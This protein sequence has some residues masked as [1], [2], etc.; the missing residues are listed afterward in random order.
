MP[1]KR[2]SALGIH[3]RGIVQ[4][5]GFRPFVYQ[6]AVKNNLTGW[7]CN[8]SD[9]VD[10][11]INGDSTSLELFLN[12]LTSSP[13]PLARIDEIKSHS[14]HPNAYTQFTILESRSDP[15]NFIPISPDISICPDCLRELFDPA[16]HRYRYPFINCTNCGPRFTI[17]KNIP[18][19]RPFTTMAEFPMC[20]DCRA[21]YDNPLDRRFHAQPVACKTCGPSLSFLEN[22][23]IT[24]SHEEALAAARSTLRVGKVLAVKGL[25]GYHLACDASNTDAVRELRRRK[26]RVEKPFALMAFDLDVIRRYCHISDQEQELLKSRQRPIVLLQRLPDCPLPEDLAPGQKTL[27]FMLPYTPLHYLLLEPE[28]GFPD[29][30]VMTS[31]NLS[32]EPIAYQDTDAMERLSPLADAFLTHNRDIHIRVDDSVARVVHKSPV[33]IRRSR[34]YAPDPLPL[35]FSFPQIFAAGAE[36]KNH[37]TLTRDSYAFH[38]H[39]I[40]DLEN[41]ETLKSYEQAVDHFENLFR[42]QP[43]MLACDLHPDY[44]STRYT[45]SRSREQNIPVVQV[46]HH[47]AH[48]AACLLDNSRAT[49]EPVIGLIFDGTGYGTDGTIWGGEVLAGG[50]TGYQRRFHLAEFRL[51][52]GD[53]AVRT[54]ARIAL[55]ILQS[56]GFDWQKDLSP[57]RYFSENE[58]EVIR[59]QILSRINTPLTTSM[60]R[61]FD[62]VSSLIGIRQQITY[63]GQAA[64]E[65]EALVDPSEKESYTFDL[66]GTIINHQKVFAQILS[67]LE[68]NL[69]TSR[70][71]AR[72][73]NAV[74]HLCLDV[75]LS[76]KEETGIKTAALSGGV[77]QNTCLY[78]KTAELLRQ[79]DIAVLTHHK[80]PANDACISLGQAVIAARFV[81]KEV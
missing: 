69:S 14:T 38:S 7:V 8:T 70:I 32:E 16:N 57:V 24:S 61:L 44:L 47:H 15:S 39:F 5:V 3:V 30:L 28:A 17:I 36:L 33:L 63:E 4:G 55:A 26:R 22:K 43:E 78:N 68:G 37:F 35:P 65:L 80:V 66:D 45:L 81:S 54:P 60:G 52:G 67:D 76:I 19:D 58:L 56:H 53:K 29:A 50:Y 41:Y 48:L 62:A 1:D 27:G 31:G 25:G 10:I 2:I 49:D 51:P 77:W 6:L 13:P 71:S 12:D 40:G 74:A 72:F 23:K 20:P 59:S 9:G 64:I 79:H 34:G 21:E 42:I 75:C 11:E 46:Q 18:Y 73:H